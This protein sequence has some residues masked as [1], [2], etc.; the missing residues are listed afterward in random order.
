MQGKEQ[1]IRA[2]IARMPQ[3][4]EHRCETCGITLSRETNVEKALLKCKAG[5]DG[6]VSDSVFCLLETV[7]DHGLCWVSAKLH[8]S[9]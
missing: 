9:L 4:E 7:R 3:G 5:E 2:A 1:L 8:E 6:V